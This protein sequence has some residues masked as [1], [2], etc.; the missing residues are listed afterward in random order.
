MHEIHKTNNY[1]IKIL[2][3]L[4]RWEERL[5]FQKKQIEKEQFL[6]QC[7]EDQRTE[8]IDAYKE[9]I[10]KETERMRSMCY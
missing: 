6:L 4:C 7:I 1:K 9:K 3:V 5:E 2:L 10:D 8:F